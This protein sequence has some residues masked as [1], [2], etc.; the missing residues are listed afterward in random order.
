MILIVRAATPAAAHAA[1]D[2]YP[3]PEDEEEDGQ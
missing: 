3:T 2:D 1:E